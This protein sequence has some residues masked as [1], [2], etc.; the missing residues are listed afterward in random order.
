MMMFLKRLETVGFKS[1]AERIQVEF[2]PGVTA[3]VGPN[4]S[5]KSNIIDAIRWVLGEQSARSL[6]GKKMEDIIFQGSDTRNALNFAEVALI[7]N[8]HDEKLPIDYNEVNITRRVYRSGESEFFINKQSCRLKDI[9]DLFMDTGLGRESFSIIGQGKID[10]ILSSKAEERRA[11]FE[12]AAGVLKYKQRKNQA[13]FKLS[14]TEDNLDRVEDIIHEIE[15]QIEPLKQQAA[16]AKQYKEKKAELKKVEIA[17][18]VTEIEQLHF[19]WKQLLSE[20]EEKKVIEVE[21]KTT[22]QKREARVAKE[23]QDIQ[24]LEGEIDALQNDL[25]T[26]TEQLEQFEGKRNVWKERLKHLQEN[27]QKLVHEKELK[28]DRMEQLKKV[29]E[30]ENE[31]FQTVTDH[32]EK[33]M[34]EKQQ[35]ERKLAQG[36]DELNIQI[37]DL[38]SDYIE[39]LNEQAVLQN[40]KKTIERQLEQVENKANSES[41]DYQHVIEK[42]EQLNSL[43]REVES[44]ITDLVNKL[45]TNEKSLIQAEEKLTK[46]RNEY[47]V[48]QQKLYEGNEQIAT[49]TSRKE[50]LEEMKDSFQG[51]FYGV[52][53]I[54]Q[55]SKENRLSGIH[56]AVVDLIEV[57]TN[58]MTAID[59]ILGAQAQYVVV[60]N[61]KVAREIIQWLKK[62]NKGRA[63]FLPIESIESRTIPNTLIKKLEQQPGFIGIA[64]DIVKTKEKFVKVIEHL[65][66]NVIL[67]EDLHHASAIAQLTNRRYRIVTLEGDIVFPGGSMSGGAK[68]KTN[69]SLFTREKEIIL[70]SDKLDRFYARRDSFIVDM[71]NV[72]DS[73]KQQ[74]EWIKQR[75][76]LRQ[77]LNETLQKE[78]TRQNEIAI[79]LQSVTDEIE[80]YRLNNKLKKEETLKL[81]TDLKNV[82]TKLEEISAQI[83]NIEKTIEKLTS[84]QQAI[85]NNKRNIENRLHELHVTIAEQEERKKSLLERMTSLNNQLTEQENEYTS[86]LSQLNQLL[87]IEKDST[88]EAQI[89]EEIDIYKNKRNDTVQTIELK[90]DERKR[91]IQLNEDEERE[92]RQLY[93]LHESF[94]QEIQEKEVQANRLDVTLENHLSFLQTEYTITYEKASR[95]YAKVNDAV[96][97]KQRVD[98]IKR[99]IKQL[100]TVNLGAIDEYDRL[101]ERYSFLS[102][103]KQDLVEA[104]N[105]LYSVIHEMD[106]EMTDRFSAMFSEI[107]SAFTVVFQ[108]LFGGGHAELQL[109]EPNNILETGIEIVARPPGKKLRTLGLLSGGERALTAIA[110]LFAIIRARPVPFCIL[111][112]VDAA[113][114]EANVERFGNYLKRFSEKTQFIVIT[115]RKGT[116]EEADA[117]YGVTMQ[118]SGVS[119]LVSVK[120]EDTT[121]L[122]EAT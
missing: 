16:T 51:Y 102:E 86:I 26:F 30:A 116:M 81:R 112:E 104:K 47:E 5:G 106:K 90:Q 92:I 84:E 33:A 55:A 13:Q 74:E 7:L 85:Q 80:T 87:E 82:T 17:L 49:I 79:K 99:S 36:L 31:K 65:M 93:K 41:L 18:L 11:I 35:L 8:N 25:L 34:A 118:E 113:L 73:I 28:T 83:S 21:K 108:Q 24:T 110:L 105:T 42:K 19:N 67:T 72:K 14:E 70:L 94:V 60:P 45:E 38:K 69:Q 64:S 111:D 71:D 68:K 78:Q 43:H 57:P 44:M 22:I 88:T 117:L 120:L 50:M 61:D 10:E 23:R 115:H 56:G 75:E 91:K 101:S 12:E 29:I 76:A 9:V 107:Q 1:F 77:E 97:A 95:Q 100:G 52:K 109:T 46:Q 58:Y 114:D 89:T 6:R 15:Q 62:E 39:Y 53:E 59:T 32:L 63:T 2:V 98:E 27:K 4:G 122:V 40:D 96:A 3:V 48:M 66:G 119:R 54:L 20:I 37:E 103:Q 121:D